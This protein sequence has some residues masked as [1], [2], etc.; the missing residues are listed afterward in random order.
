[1]S[2]RTAKFSGINR[3]MYDNGRTRRRRRGKDLSVF[4]RITSSGLIIDQILINSKLTRRIESIDMEI[5]FQ[6]KTA[7][8]F[9]RPNVGP[10]ICQH[11][12]QIDAEKRTTKLTALTTAGLS[13]V[14]DFTST[15]ETIRVEQMLGIG[16]GISRVFCLCVYFVKNRISG[17]FSIFEGLSNPDC[18]ESLSVDFQ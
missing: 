8:F 11:S 4:I 12:V 7:S 10:S 13:S 2:L 9:S 18:V 6:Q 1:M 15:E 3:M 16:R 17:L 5:D 14:S